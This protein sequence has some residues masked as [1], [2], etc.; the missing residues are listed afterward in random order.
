MSRLTALAWGMTLSLA[1][2]AAHAELPTE[3]RVYDDDIVDKGE[4][5]FEIH[6]SR[7]LRAKPRD[8]ASRDLETN[9]GLR[10]TPEISYGINEHTEI[11]ILIPTLLDSNGVGYIGGQQLQVKW[12]GQRA[13]AQGGWFWGVNG[14][15]VTATRNFDEMRNSVEIRPILGYRNQDW[16]AI[17]NLL[18]SY[19]LTEG[20]RTGG[21]NLK[22]AFKLAHG[23]AEGAQLGV[24]YYAELGKI[25]RLA[26][27][28]E[29]VQTAYLTLDVKKSGWK[30][31]LGL[32]RGL[33]SG[34]DPW[35][36]K[37]I[38]EFPLDD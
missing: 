13:P 10:I 28:A 22:P 9:R 32:G 11:S 14:E 12:F 17:A 37:T 31:N 20:Y 18:L 35:I 2:M 7:T 24:E 30:V 21:L 26:P 27:R 5:G 23:V 8:D 19:G 38:I 16:Q 3:I 33:T 34:T 25:T 15:L 6:A 1:A 29:Q 4:Y 36:L